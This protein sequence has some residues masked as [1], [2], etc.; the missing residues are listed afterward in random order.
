MQSDI[1]LKVL[2]DKKNMKKIRKSGKNS[3][4]KGEELVIT[5]S[6]KSRKPRKKIDTGLDKIRAERKKKLKNKEKAKQLSENL[7]EKN[8]EKN[9]VSKSKKIQ[10]TFYEANGVKKQKTMSEISKFSEKIGISDCEVSEAV[11]EF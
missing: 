5:T 3:T 4:K 10:K 9:Q 1:P 11:S 2:T 8:K 7:R 6:R